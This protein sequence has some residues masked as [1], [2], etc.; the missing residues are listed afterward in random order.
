MTNISLD[1]LA[2][3]ADRGRRKRFRDR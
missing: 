3:A 2:A 1:P